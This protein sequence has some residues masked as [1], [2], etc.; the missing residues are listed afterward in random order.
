MYKSIFGNRSA[1]SWHNGLYHIYGAP[2]AF[3]L[4]LKRAKARLCFL[5][6][7]IGNK[8]YNFIGFII[9]DRELSRDY[10]FFFIFQNGA[11]SGAA[12]GFP[13]RKT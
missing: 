11:T 13:R 8:K 9:H 3:R 12:V 6:R 10:Y 5:H 4:E 2:I 7:F 1:L